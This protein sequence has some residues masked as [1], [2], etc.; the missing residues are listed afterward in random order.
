[1]FS[2]KRVVAPHTA[3]LRAQAG[4]APA[5][6]GARPALCPLQAI[7][8]KAAVLW[9]LNQP[10]SIEEVEVAPPRAHEVRIKMVAAGICRSDD[11]A[12]N[13]SFAIP[14]PVILGHEAAGVVESI[15]EGVTSVK[16]GDKVIPLFVP[17]CG[18]CV[19]CE[20][21]EGNFCIKNDLTTRRGTMQDQ[22]GRF[23]CRGKPIH[24][25]LGTSTFSQYTV[26]DENAV[27]RVDAAAPLDKVCLI[28]CGFSTGYGS[29]VKVAKVTR[30]ST[31]VVF[32]LGGVG[33]S[34]V[35]GCKAAGAARIIGVDINKDKFARAR[36]VGA[37]E[38]MSPQDSQRPVYEVLQEMTGGGA[39]FAF[40]V[41]GRLDT[42]MSAV[43]CS[44]QA[45]GVSVIV[46]VAPGSKSLSLNP[47]LLLSG[48]TLKGGLF[49]GL[50]SRDSV[51]RLVAEF[52]AKKFTLDPL[53]T[54]VLPFEK[55]NEG[56]DLL[57]AGKRRRASSPVRQTITCRAAVAWA[58]DAP[59]TMEDVQ[60]EP[61]K[62]GEVRIKM[63][64]SSICGTDD[65]AVRGWLPMTFPFIPGH[66]G[67]G[68]VESVGA[69][70]HSVRPGDKV[71]TLIIPQCRECSSCLHPRGNFCLK[72]ESV[73]VTPP[74][75]LSLLALPCAAKS[76]PL[77]LCP[78]P[79][80][81]P[82]LATRDSVLPS[83]GLMLDGTS[84]FSCKGKQLHHSFRASTF[85]EYTV[86]P[87]IAVVRIDA[88]A[89]MDKVCIFSC[90]VPTGFGAAVHSA[91][92]TPGST[93]VVFGLGGIG[94]AIVLG[95][96]ASGA[97]RIIGVDINEEKF[98]RAQALGV[99]DC[100]NPR[101]LQKPVQEVVLEMTGLGVDFAFEAVGLTETM[102]AAWD[103]CNLSHGV[104]CIVGLASPGMQL[105]L[106][107]ATLIA[108]RTLKGVCLGDYKTRDCVPQLVADFLQCRLDVGALVTHQLPFA[109]LHQA[110]ELYRAGKTIRCV[111]RCRAAVAWTA[112]APLSIEE[113]EVDPPKAGE[114]RIK[115]L[116]SGICGTD[117]HI[118]EGRNKVPFPV[119]LGH[120]GAG[121]VESVGKGI[122]SLKPGDKVLAF[123]LPQCR[124]CSS[125]LHPRGNFC[126]KQDILSPTGLMLDG[127]SRFSCRG[128]KIHHLY[129]TSTFAEYTVVSEIAA[130]KIDAAAPMDRVC[131]FSCEVPT[132]FGAVLNTA[133]VSSAV[134]R[135]R[136]ERR[137][138]RFPQHRRSGSESC[139]VSPLGLQV[140]PGSTCV[141]FGL[142]G[143]GSAI[144]LGC[145][146]SGA[147]RIIGV[148]I[149]EEKFPRAQA[150][151][152]TDC[153]NP[154]KLQKPVQ[155]VVLEM[156][157][158]GVDF[159][160]EAVGLTETMAAALESCRLSFGVCVIVGT[161]PSGSRLS[162]D[163][164]L[165]L[166]GRTLKGG[167][168]GEYKAR[169]SVP[170]LVTDYLQKRID[171]DPL[172]THKLPFEKINK[173]FE[174][175]RDGNCVWYV[176]MY[177]VAEQGPQ[178]DAQGARD[179]DTPE[180][181]TCP[182]QAGHGAL[183]VPGVGR[184]PGD[185]AQADLGQVQVVLPIRT[186]RG[187][188]VPPRWLASGQR[189][190]R[191]S[192]TGS[193]CQRLCL[194]S[195]ASCSPATP[196]LGACA[197]LASGHASWGVWRKGDS[198]RLRSP[199]SDPPPPAGLFQHPLR[200]PA[201]SPGGGL[202]SLSRDP[203]PPPAH[204][205]ALDPHGQ[206]TRGCEE[207]SRHSGI[208]TLHA[209][210][211]SPLP[212]KSA[213]RRGAGGAGS[214]APESAFLG[215]GQG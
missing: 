160:F 120:E 86:L 171:I 85:T 90:E 36:E 193:G 20:H 148:D 4:C 25:F 10:F 48:R 58:A 63:V 205:A 99:T 157:G 127:T 123:P 182:G 39:D 142:G 13:G 191:R 181:V 82:R 149:N 8:C 185:R 44:H 102:V 162:F 207:R 166:S 202:P 106:D 23:S 26:V 215:S 110:F 57:R 188:R 117:M 78:P 69:A 75:S 213:A 196:L 68:V 91:K 40:E 41:I 47:G 121:V 107:A 114:V 154:R 163:P 101:K 72:Q 109:Q 186:R 177:V 190:R 17:Q 212:G 125:C 50:K 5:R 27:A 135:H 30:G 118:L 141:V 170:K 173:A 81:L 59:L 143:I 150:L 208:K 11:H 199:G 49:G 156:T 105:R 33:L 115:I 159:A 55:I 137:G 134:R 103:S 126:L 76:P 15:G 71:L 174:L 46:G 1:V 165:L 194:C 24:H 53:I 183:W 6:P 198:A 94:S 139:A 124:E 187:A 161:A 98:P 18:K 167:A 2:A 138:L 64:S 92:V 62:A 201:L 16:P 179:W 89:P 60:V 153:L 88:A 209:G 136:P 130:A 100:L 87:E 97:S 192:H 116:S 206:S 113:V 131:V 129:G 84:R 29:A 42:I 32:G 122:T 146:A 28:G 145:K 21:P 180:E 169:D 184:G 19:V 70:V 34:V 210:A 54:H 168:L 73:S 119:I 22:T 35:M 79:A 172:I 9:E 3:L 195:P 45:F 108:G 37:T 56:F 65:H 96:K 31:C 197:G 144:V 189:S 151:G 211:G 7:K 178:P 77:S 152:V 74:P 67:A 80:A 203:R 111:I 52:M 147:S 66:E 140:T 128:R 164:A 175:L 83:T 93:C 133:K 51:P 204:G 176:C 214:A 95:C 12:V 155:E 200:P 43:L 112:R 104:C 14:L 38:C 158:L 132:G 61:P